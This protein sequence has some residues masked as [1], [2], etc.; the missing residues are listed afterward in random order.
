[1][2]KPVD[3][4]APSVNRKRLTDVQEVEKWLLRNFKQVY[5]REGTAREKGDALVF[6]NRQ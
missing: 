3:P 5:N 1:V 6:I 4:L 2:G